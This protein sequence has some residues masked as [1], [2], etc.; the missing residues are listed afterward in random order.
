MHYLK[1]SNSPLDLKLPTPRLARHS[2]PINYALTGF[3]HAIANLITNAKKRAR[4][5]SAAVYELPI[6]P[7]HQT[8]DRSAMNDCP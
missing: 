7:E 2:I 5:P 6:K 3:H 1:Q 8:R 4:F